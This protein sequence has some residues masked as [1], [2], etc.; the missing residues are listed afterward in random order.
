MPSKIKIYTDGA[1]RGN[2]G[3]AGWAA[4][5]F[6]ENNCG[7]SH[8]RSNL[9]CEIG[10]HKNHATNNQME[11]TAPI[12]ALKYV[13]NNITKAPPDAFAQVLGSPRPL[14]SLLG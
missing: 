7:P 2:P 14:P 9:L 5:I 3:Q 13:L 11:L 10:G 6:E 4:I 1:A 12:E 8:K